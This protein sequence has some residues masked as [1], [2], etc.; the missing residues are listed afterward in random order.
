MNFADTN[1]LEAMFFDLADPDKQSRPAIVRR[2]LRQHGGPILLSHLV[3]LEAR[4]VFTRVS[5]E[6]GPEEWRQL[7]Q[8][9]NGRFY[10]DPMNWDYLRRDAF[11]L[12]ARYGHKATLGTFDLALLASAKLSGATRLLSFDQTLK[13][14][15]VAEGLDVF[16]PLN[17][18]GRQLLARLKRS[19]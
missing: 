19:G 8:D 9:L 10:L 15:A 1:W 12:I 13:A 2:F 6:A 5:G 14:L 18:A 11:E 3:Y 16:P 7:Q 17:L 4:N